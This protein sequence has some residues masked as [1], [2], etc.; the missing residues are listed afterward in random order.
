MKQ[1]HIQKTIRNTLIA[2][3]ACSGI[4]FLYRVFHKKPHVRVVVFHNIVER[5]WFASMIE[6][7]IVEFHVLTPNDFFAQRFVKDRINVLI[8]FDDGYASWK[9]LALPVL[10]THNCKALFFVN[11]GLL[12]VA[13]DQKKTETF[14]KE[15]LLISPKEPLTWDDLKILSK[16]GHAIG[17]HTASHIHM[18]NTEFEIIKN[19]IALDKTSIESHI[20]Q[21]ITEFAYPFGTKQHVTK[22][23]SDIVKTLG[24]TR[25]YTA[26]SRFVSDGDSYTISRMCIEDNLTKRQLTWWVSG[27]YDLFDILKSLCVR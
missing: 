10:D 13:E 20:G 26:I 21:P 15:K 23:G 18:G 4:A 6:T 8:T 19:E 24:Y 5:D 17:G 1:R 22:V 12:D 14:M 25:A 16:T 3:F 11:S 2:F 7:L 27:A 9:T